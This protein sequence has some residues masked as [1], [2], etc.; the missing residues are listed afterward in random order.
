VQITE[1]CVTATVRIVNSQD[2]FKTTTIDNTCEGEG[3]GRLELDSKKKKIQAHVLPRPMSAPWRRPAALPLPHQPSS[4][5]WPCHASSCR[6]SSGFHSPSIESPPDRL[7]YRSSSPGPPPARFAAS[8]EIVE[9]H[10][11]TS[12][13][14]TSHGAPN[15]VSRDA[16]PTPPIT[17][18]Y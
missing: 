16:P 13:K 2:E 15:I 14:Q 5:L 4:P 10:E 9:V 1:L 8:E 18:H 3:N 17:G 12:R 11:T 7:M 6:P